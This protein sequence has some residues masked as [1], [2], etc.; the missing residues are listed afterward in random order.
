MV[1]LD[2]RANPT[3]RF[4]T[5]SEMTGATHEQ[6]ATKGTG[7]ELN[8]SA[9]TGTLCRLMHPIRD[10]E[11]RVR[12]EECPRILRKIINLEREMFLVKFDDGAT[13]FVFPDEIAPC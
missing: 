9:L 8:S 3:R 10:R 11:G 5:K 4:G 2:N 7:M 1:V 12:F 6:V 13:T